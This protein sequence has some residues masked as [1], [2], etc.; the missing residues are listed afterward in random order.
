MEQSI[1]SGL[2]DASALIR[3]GAGQFCGILITTN[4]TNAATAIVYDG[5]TATGTE[6]FKGVVAG[7]SNFDS[8]FPGLSVKAR[9]GIYVSI[10]GTGAKFI[11][12]TR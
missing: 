11:A 12:Y 1:S 9:T 7:A 4:G 3:T 6:L 10:S 8:F 5:L 2:K